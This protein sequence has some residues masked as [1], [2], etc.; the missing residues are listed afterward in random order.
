MNQICKLN[1]LTNSVFSNVNGYNLSEGKQ[2]GVNTMSAYD[3]ARLFNLAMRYQL[4]VKI[5]STMEYK[6]TNQLNIW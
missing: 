1:S 2:R 3:L 4:F 6:S 5:I